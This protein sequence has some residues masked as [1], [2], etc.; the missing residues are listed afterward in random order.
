MTFLI[1][2]QSH[3]TCP[4]TS[5]VHSSAVRSTF[6]DTCSTRPRASDFQNEQERIIWTFCWVRT[7]TQIRVTAYHFIDTAENFYGLTVQVLLYTSQPSCHAGLRFVAWFLLF[8]SLIARR[9]CS[10]CD[11]TC[12][13]KPVCW[14]SLTSSFLELNTTVVVDSIGFWRWCIILRITGFLEF[15]H[16]PVFQKLE[17]T[18]FRKLDLSWVP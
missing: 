10:D 14:T 15:V 2:T 17:N 18:T 13:R 16:R 7:K 9:K 6:I 4:E 11:V 3:A 5:V 1:A 8:I 12:E